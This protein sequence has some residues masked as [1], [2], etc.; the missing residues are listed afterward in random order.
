[1][2]FTARKKKYVDFSRYTF[3]YLPFLAG[4][5]HKYGVWDE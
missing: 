2:H 5:D 4:N 3:S 1:M